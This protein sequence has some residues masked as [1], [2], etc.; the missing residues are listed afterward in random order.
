[1]KNVKVRIYK[2][3]IILPVV[4]YGCETWSMTLRQENNLLRRTFGPERDEGKGGWRKLHN[5]ELHDLY[6]S[7]NII[8]IIIVKED[9]LGSV[10]S[11][12]G[13]RKGTHIGYWWESQRERD[14]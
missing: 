2:T 10:C 6:A 14:H 12:N 3:I 9:E 4:P 8:R 11:T 13:G 7:P 1:L 5:D